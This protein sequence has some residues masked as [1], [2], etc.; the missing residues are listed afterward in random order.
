[1]HGQQ[2]GYRAGAYDWLEHWRARYDAER[3]QAEAVAPSSAGDHWQGRAARF[4]SSSQRTPQPDA[5]LSFLLPH[6]RPDDCVIDIGAGSG[7]YTPL[8]A[9]HTAR[10]IAIE[11][12]AAMRAYLEQRVEDEG[13]N[14]VEIVAETWPPAQLPRADVVFAAHVLYAVRD[15]EPFLR[16]MHAS[17]R[18]LCALFLMVQHFNMLFSPFWQRFHGEPRLP[19]PAALEAYNALYQ[20][21]YAA[22]MKPTP[23]K[24]LTYEDINAA[25][26]DICPRL[27]LPPLPHD[28]NA[29]RDAI[30][31]FMVQHDDGSL[32]FAG[33]SRYNAIISWQPDQVLATGEA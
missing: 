1:M 14:N 13:L 7:R 5:F 22:T 28:D 27:R 10:V 4:A 23:A 19:L 8:L 29:L 18:R 24:M 31:E 6:L 20:L 21:G 30:R 11:P 32:T 9:Q 33:P 15:I 12:S 26:D 3:A 16:A 2:A 17:A 25:I